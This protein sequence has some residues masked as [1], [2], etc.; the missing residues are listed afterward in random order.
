MKDTIREM[1]G[2]IYPERI[3]VTPPRQTGQHR[4]RLLLYACFPCKGMTTHGNA[5]KQAAFLSK[6]WRQPSADC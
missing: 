2:I 6:W 4:H 1:I 5:N 3:S